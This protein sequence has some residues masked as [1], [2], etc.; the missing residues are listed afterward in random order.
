M[1]GILLSITLAGTAPMLLMVQFATQASNKINALKDFADLDTPPITPILSARRVP[2]TLIDLTLK[3]R[4]AG[5]LKP[6]A[7]TLPPESCL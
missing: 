2:Q 5:K 7:A 4:V 3:V 6:L 1:V